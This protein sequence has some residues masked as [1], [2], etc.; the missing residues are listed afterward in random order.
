[1]VGVL[2]FP[3]SREDPLIVLAGYCHAHVAVTYV[4]GPF[5]AVLKNRLL[6]ATVITTDVRLALS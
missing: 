4:G 3:T 6:L 1:M 2:G 5:G